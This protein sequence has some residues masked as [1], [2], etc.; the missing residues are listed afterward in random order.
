MKHRSKKKL[1]GARKNNLLIALIVVAIFGLLGLIS[2]L[3]SHAATPVAAG[4]AES[5]TLGSSASLITD[6]NASGTKAVTFGSSSTTPPPG[7]CTNPIGLRPRLQVP[8]PSTVAERGGST[9]T[10]GTAATAPKPSMSAVN[11]PG[12]LFLINRMSRDK[13]RPSRQRI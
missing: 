4:E 13:W 7:N 3:S 12:M 10:P 1:A 6:P 2:L 8:T 5:G 11:H 9:T